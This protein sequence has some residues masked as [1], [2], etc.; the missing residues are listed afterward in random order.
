LRRRRVRMPL[1]LR[2]T[3]SDLRAAGVRERKS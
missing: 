2:F 1:N 3:I